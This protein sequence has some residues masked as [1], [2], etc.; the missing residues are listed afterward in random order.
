MNL[1]SLFNML[2]QL[3]NVAY[4]FSSKCI[5]TLAQKKKK[6]AFFIYLCI[7]SELGEKFV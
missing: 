4:N 7:L 6:S 1:G 2:A 5:E 3:K